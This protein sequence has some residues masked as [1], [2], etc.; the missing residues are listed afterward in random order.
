[1]STRQ[2]ALR[3][4][5]AASSAPVTASPRRFGLPASAS[6][7]A[8]AAT[9]APISAISSR[10]DG[11]GQQRL[12]R[13]LPALS[14]AAGQ[15]AGVEHGRVGAGVQVGQ[16]GRAAAQ[17]VGLVRQVAGPGKLGRGEPRGH[18]DEPGRHRAGD[19]RRPAAARG[20]RPGRELIEET[21]YRLVQERA[22]ASR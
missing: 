19:R 12:P 3:A 1:M 9:R 17:L 13:P 2:A 20:R 22:H 11:R 7:A 21:P 6:C 16:V 18:G 15:A 5:A 8:I 4:D 10:H 14:V